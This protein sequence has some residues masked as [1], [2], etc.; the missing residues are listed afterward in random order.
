M[1]GETEKKAN[2]EENVPVTPT[3]AG[4]SQE[5]IPKLLPVLPLSDVVLF[6]SMVA[7]LVVTTAKSIRLID[8]VVS[9]NRFLI[10]VLQKNRAAQD[11]E[12]AMT[13]ERRGDA[14]TGLLERALR[15]LTQKTDDEWLHANG[16]G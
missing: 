2:A 14:A 1:A 11:D 9:G 15:I 10:T 13:P 6:P 16:W 5:V 12:V 4:D 7:P 8:T 3:P